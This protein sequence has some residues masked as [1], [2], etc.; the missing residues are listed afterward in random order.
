MTYNEDIEESIQNCEDLE[1]VIEELIQEYTDTPQGQKKKLQLEI[2]S[3]IKS[4]KTDLDFIDC[5]IT[6]MQ[7]GKVKDEYTEKYNTHKQT[8]QELE[9]A[10]AMA[11]KPPEEQNNNVSA[12]E[13]M[14]KAINLQE[15]QKNSLSN[16]I[17]MAQA[18]QDLGQDSL[19][20]IKRQQDQ[21][22]KMD[23]DLDVMDSEIDRAKVILKQMVNRAA[24]DN[25]VRVLII[26][27]LLAII[28]VIVTEIVAPGT[29]KNQV[30]KG[31]TTEGSGS[32]QTEI[33]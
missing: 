27:V 7:D 29:I 30:E 8:V 23:Q 9:N 33:I 6:E 21:M 15:Q 3:K 1:K 32:N 20:E 10:L 19:V 5:E 26:I 22:N 14:G 25:C 16:T 18:S 11:V 24:G 28:G 31:F 2:E 13:L 17:Q 12:Q 4:L